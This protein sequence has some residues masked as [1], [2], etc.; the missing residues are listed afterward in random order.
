MPVP[1]RLWSKDQYEAAFS[2]RRH[3]LSEQVGKVSVALAVPEK[4]DIDPASVVL[5]DQAA[6]EQVNLKPRQSDLTS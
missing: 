1:A 2:E 3:F 5:V 4:Y 6:T